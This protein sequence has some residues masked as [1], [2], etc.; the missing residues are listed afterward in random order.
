MQAT[1]IGD[2]NEAQFSL[3]VPVGEYAERREDSKENEMRCSHGV[4]YEAK[5]TECFGEAMAREILR[6]AVAH[7]RPSVV[8]NV[9][10]S[11]VG[12]LRPTQRVMAQIRLSAAS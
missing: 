11:S 12:Y 2:N 9:R 4:P 10:F 6:P 3:Q 1:N 5:C 7:V 8:A